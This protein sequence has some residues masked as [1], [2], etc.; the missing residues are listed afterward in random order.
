MKNLAHIYIPCVMSGL[1]LAGCH[2][3]SN[4]EVELKTM[5][6]KIAVEFS[7]VS[8]MSTTDLAAWIAD[9]ARKPPQLLDAREPD[10][11]AVSHLHGAIRVAPDSTAEQLSGRVDFSRPI[12]VYCSVG[13]RSSILARRLTAA[14]QPLSACAHR[15]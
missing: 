5:T 11:Y 7:D 3:A 14:A 10:E 2:K 4:P 9:P 12:V 1:V 13:Y 8:H 15:Q 6:G